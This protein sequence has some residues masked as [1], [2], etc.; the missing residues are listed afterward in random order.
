[1][2]LKHRHKHTHTHTSQFQKTFFIYPKRL[3]SAPRRLPKKSLLT[4]SLHSSEVIKEISE[5]FKSLKMTLTEGTYHWHLFQSQ[6]NQHIH[7]NVQSAFLHQKSLTMQVCKNYTR[8]SQCPDNVM[9]LQ[10]ERRYPVG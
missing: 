6:P 10:T 8:I 7:H 3:T 1:M 5:F 9:D 4:I 2:K